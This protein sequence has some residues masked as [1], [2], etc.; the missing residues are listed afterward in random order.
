MR[1][2]LP[3]RMHGEGVMPTV[4]YIEDHD[5]NRV[6][7][8]RVLMACDYDIALLEASS[9][10]QGI[11]LAR[12][13]RPDLILMDLSMPG[14]DGLAAT[15]R[16]RAIPELAGVPVVA[17]TANVM[18]GDRKRSLDAGCSGY[19]SKPIDV[20][21]FPDEIIACLERAREML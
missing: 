11:A 13:R 12:E 21:R 16:L 3:A 17:L 14:M 1:A 10:E 6:L 8:R 7:V 18:D 20:D 4:L 19:I 15:R 9:A 2:R 5:D